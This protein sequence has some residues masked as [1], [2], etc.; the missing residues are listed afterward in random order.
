MEE[1]LSV[2]LRVLRTSE[3]IRNE[4][5]RYTDHAT[6][7]ASGAN[8]ALLFVTGMQSGQSYA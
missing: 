7:Y 5:L 3:N 1:R 2:L 8:E 4:E 6:Y